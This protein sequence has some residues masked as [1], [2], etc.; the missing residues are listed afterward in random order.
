MEK[1]KN[2][3]KR[4]FLKT[5]SLGLGS[6]ILAQTA[7]GILTSR[8]LLSSGILLSQSALSKEKTRSKIIETALGKVQG[9]VSQ[10]VSVF[11]GIPYGASTS[12]SNRFRPPQPAAPWRGVKE[13]IDYGQTTPQTLSPSKKLTEGHG[14][15]CLVLNIWTPAF[16]ASENTSASQVKTKRPVMFWCHGGGLSS[17]SGSSPSYDG[18]NL[19]NRGDVVVVTVNHRLNVMGFCHLAEQGGEDF[20]S[21]GTVGMQDLIAAL[22]W[23][24]TNIEAFGGDPDN[25]MIFGESGGGRKVGTLLGMPAAKGLFHRAAIQSGPTIQLVN[26]E[27]AHILSEKLMAELGLKKGEIKKAQQLPPE[28][29]IAAYQKLTRTHGYSATTNGFA[30]VVDGHTLPYHPFHPKASPVN[31]DIP[32]LIGA[33]RTELTLQMRADKS[34]FN[35]TFKDLPKRLSSVGK[36]RTNE[37]I[38][39]Y[40]AENP[41]ASASEI[42]FLIV[43]D[44]RYVIP[45]QVIAERRAA[46]KAA[47]VYSYYLTWKTNTFNGQLMTPHALDIP[48]VFDNTDTEKTVY[49]FTTGTKEERDLADKISD[50]WIAFARSGNPNNN[51]IPTWKEYSEDQRHQMILDNDIKLANDP[52]K[53]QRII[54]SDVLGLS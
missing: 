38:T 28:Q 26:E 2:L 11:K 10:G 35:L 45:C 6:G 52:I 24:K 42:F 46:L 39:T 4:Q 7:T 47:P 23:V 36:D 16:S 51:K 20:A 49:G 34:A 29:I 53:N 27:D 12:G 22:T 43:S 54:M 41:T 9:Y 37:L 31:P 13:S 33:N 5:G 21:S 1:P 8:T 17:Y 40:R 32:L 30:P 50:T 3:S 19:C 15:D 14:E 18:T 48:F 44:A 25:V